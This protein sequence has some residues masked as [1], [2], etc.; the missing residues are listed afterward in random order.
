MAS[1][2]RKS[3]SVACHP[4]SHSLP[5][6]LQRIQPGMIQ[7]LGVLEQGLVPVLPHIGQ[8]SVHDLIYIGLLPN[9]PVQDLVQ[10]DLVR[11]QDPHH[12]T[13]TCSVFCHLADDLIFKF[14]AGLVGDQPGADGHEFGDHLQ[15]VFRRVFPLSTISTITSLSPRMGASSM[16]PLRWMISMSRFRSA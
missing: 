14:E 11:L 16:L 8:N 1:V 3:S 13:T 15:V 5:A 12:R 6:D 4:A 2:V 7:L 9:I 10:R